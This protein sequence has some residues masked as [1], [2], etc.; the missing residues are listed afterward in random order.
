MPVPLGAVSLKD[1]SKEDP[2]Y[3]NLLD[4]ELRYINRNVTAIL[5]R[6][7]Y[8]YE[9][10]VVK[11]EPEMIKNCCDFKALE[12]ACAKYIDSR[13]M[14]RESENIPTVPRLDQI[15][16]QTEN[17]YTDIH[18]TIVKARGFKPQQRITPPEGLDHNREHEPNI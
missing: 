2:K 12:S 15:I 3:R 8:V 18:E 16:E 9:S 14:A 4:I 1:F 6:A 13:P 17:G 11:A 5:T 7:K 10:V